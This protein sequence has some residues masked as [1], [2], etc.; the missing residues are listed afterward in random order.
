MA[1]TYLWGDSQ[2]L[3]AGGDVGEGGAGEG[4]VAEVDRESLAPHPEV[5]DVEYCQFLS[6]IAYCLSKL[7]RYNYVG[8]PAESKAATRDLI[9]FL[10]CLMNRHSC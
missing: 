6:M 7:T 2:H 8:K 5:A 1:T 10:L 3:E 9:G 4:H